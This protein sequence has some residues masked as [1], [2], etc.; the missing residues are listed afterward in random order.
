[1]YGFNVMNE[2]NCLGNNIWHTCD[3]FDLFGFLTAFAH[4]KYINIK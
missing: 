2:Q 4:D 1:M 3:S